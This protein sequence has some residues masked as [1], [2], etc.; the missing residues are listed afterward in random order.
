MIGDQTMQIMRK[1]I[2]LVPKQMHNCQ[3]FVINSFFFF[4][5]GKQEET[6]YYWKYLLYMPFYFSK[7]IK[8]SFEKSK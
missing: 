4:F 8:E 6:K 2:L 1:L 7:A 5:L 3:G